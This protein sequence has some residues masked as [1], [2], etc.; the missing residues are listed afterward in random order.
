MDNNRARAEKILDS[1]I[2]SDGMQVMYRSEAIRFIHAALFDAVREAE[3][4][5]M[6][7]KIH[8]L[9]KECQVWYERG[10]SAGIEKAAGVAEKHPA[11]VDKGPG[12]KNVYVQQGRVIAERIRALKADNR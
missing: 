3:L 1:V 8:S 11:F 2:D 9:A 10:F 6:E 12:L 4:N 5:A 7:M